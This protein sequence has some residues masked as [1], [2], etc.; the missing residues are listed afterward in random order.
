MQFKRI[1]FEA[2]RKFTTKNLNERT[3]KR[4]EDFSSDDVDLVNRDISRG[5]LPAGRNF[6]F[7][8]PGTQKEPGLCTIYAINMEPMLSECFQM[9]INVLSEIKT[10]SDYIVLFHSMAFL[11]SFLGKNV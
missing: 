3:S 4:I 10:I 8:K 6:Q 11:R 7:R 5:S 1:D 2:K 9:D